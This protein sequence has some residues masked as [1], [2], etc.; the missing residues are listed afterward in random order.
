MNPEDLIWL[1]AF[2]AWLLS[3]LLGRAARK[4]LR[5]DTEAQPP[6]GSA[7]PPAPPPLRRRLVE[8]LAGLDQE[9]EPLEAPTWRPVPPPPA[10]PRSVSSTPR[11]SSQPTSPRRLPASPEAPAPREARR[12][13]LAGLRRAMVLAE[14]LGRPVSLR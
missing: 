7:H 5:N 2:A 9:D 4:R 13:H 10:A 1:I 14:V 6:A 11:Q 12:A 3:G 8:Q